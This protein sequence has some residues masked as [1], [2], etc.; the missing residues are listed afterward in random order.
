MKERK[1]VL[2]EVVFYLGRKYRDKILGNEGIAVSCCSHLTRCDQILLTW[3]DSTG[4]PVDHWIDIVNIEAVEVKV[5]PGGPA[6][7][8]NTL[9]K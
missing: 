8:F 2:N 4:R 9:N 5:P 3:N 7:R 6:P 1:V